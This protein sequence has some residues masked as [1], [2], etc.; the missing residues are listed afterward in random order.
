[1]GVKTLWLTELTYI[2]RAVTT[3][4]EQGMGIYP[5]DADTANLAPHAS[6]TINLRARAA[7]AARWLYYG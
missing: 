7:A 6:A 3:Y 2:G 5:G 1:M 4:I